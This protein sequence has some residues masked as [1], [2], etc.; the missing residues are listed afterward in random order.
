MLLFLFSVHM[1]IR[2]CMEHE[3]ARATY[4]NT[5]VSVPAPKLAILHLKSWA[6]ELLDGATCNEED[7]STILC[8]MWC[9]WTSRNARTLGEAPKNLSSSSRASGLATQRSTSFKQLRSH[10]GHLRNCAM[11]K[12]THHRLGTSASDL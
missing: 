4:P 8:G 3:R 7:G 11:R 12:G 10:C 2:D 9:L 6:I 1:C 5:T